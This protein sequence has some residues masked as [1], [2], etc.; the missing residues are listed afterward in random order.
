MPA[1]VGE[2]GTYYL[3]FDSHPSLRFLAWVDIVTIGV[4]N[5]QE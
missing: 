3:R 2:E 1:T 5:G 4:E